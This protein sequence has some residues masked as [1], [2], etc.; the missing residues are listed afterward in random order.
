MYMDL[1]RKLTLIN[2]REF[3]EKKSLEEYPSDDSD[4][5]DILEEFRREYIRLRDKGNNRR[6]VKTKQYPIAEYRQHVC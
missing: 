2:H 1:L 5:E 3:W 6:F 4:D